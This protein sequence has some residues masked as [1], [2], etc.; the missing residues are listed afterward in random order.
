ML[1]SHPRLKF[2]ERPW[3]GIGA[4]GIAK[5]HG[6]GVLVRHAL[7]DTV[8]IEVDPAQRDANAATASFR[9]S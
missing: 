8:M 2:I 5:G 9:Y 6:I 4:F 1:F 3:F 7:T